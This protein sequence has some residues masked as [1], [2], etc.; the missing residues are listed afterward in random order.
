M[1]DQIF[2]GGGLSQM[3]MNS[4]IEGLDKIGGLLM[5]IINLIKLNTKSQEK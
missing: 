1:Q 3:Q 5:E 2:G 4:V